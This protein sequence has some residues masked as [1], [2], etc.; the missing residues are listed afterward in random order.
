MAELPKTMRSLI[1]PNNQ[2]PKS[3]VVTDFPTPRITNPN[4]VIVRSYAAGPGAG[5]VMMTSG[6]FDFIHKLE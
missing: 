5:E 6:G 1:A 4:Q 2:G 3:Y